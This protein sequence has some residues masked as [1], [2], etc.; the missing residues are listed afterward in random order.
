MYIKHNDKSLYRYDLVEG[1][2]IEY[3]ASKQL[4]E[5]SRL[6]ALVRIGYVSGVKLKLM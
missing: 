6:A 5:Y 3:G 4:T 1:I 2:H